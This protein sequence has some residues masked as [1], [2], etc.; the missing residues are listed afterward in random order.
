MFEE[1]LCER[2][3]PCS[4]GSDLALEGFGA[5]VRICCAFVE[6]FVVL[7]MSRFGDYFRRLYR[8]RL[9]L[10]EPIP[11]PHYVKSHTFSEVL[12]ICVKGSLI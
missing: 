11:R 12:P 8:D 4:R 1:G 2:G 3:K 7:S 9:R 10:L 5:L 6:N